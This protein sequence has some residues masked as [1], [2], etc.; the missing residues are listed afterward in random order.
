[1]RFF[2][3]SDFDL[4]EG[5]LR[6]ENDLTECTTG[7]PGPE[8]RLAVDVSGDVDDIEVLRRP[9]LLRFC[10]CIFLS[11]TKKNSKFFWALRPYRKSEKRPS[12]RASDGHNKYLSKRWRCQDA[13]QLAGGHQTAMRTAHDESGKKD[14]F[15]PSSFGLYFMNSGYN[16]WLYHVCL[17]ILGMYTLVLR[18]EW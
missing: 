9:W 2:G 12:K 10:F 1:M 13:C 3:E 17:L 14:T 5:G 11:L 15:L 8:L 6:S 7:E 16:S 4:A 18:L